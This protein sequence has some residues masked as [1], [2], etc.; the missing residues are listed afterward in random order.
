M[1]LQLL[2]GTEKTGIAL[3]TSYAMQPGS[4]VCGLV[5]THPSARY[6]TVGPIG[7]DQ[8]DDYARRKGIAAADLPRLVGAS[9]V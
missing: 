4:A 7:D 9:L 5:F 2:G 6:F 8:A 3:T 1:I